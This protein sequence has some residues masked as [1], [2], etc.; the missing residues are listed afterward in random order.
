MK[1]RRR[2]ERFT[3]RAAAKIEKEQETGRRRTYRLVTRDI[4]SGGAFVV[5]SEPLAEGE[6]VSMEMLLPLESLSRIAGTSARVFLSVKGKVVRTDE[7]GM[8]I[9]F[10]GRHK[11]SLAEN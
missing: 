7:R 3:L 11:I 6:T 10:N 9:T 8:A 5:T 4:S 2:L 1:D